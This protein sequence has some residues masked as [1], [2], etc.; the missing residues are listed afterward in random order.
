MKQRHASF[1]LF[2]AV[3]L[4]LTGCS[5]VS[6][7]R[8]RDKNDSAP[9][10]AVDINKIPNAVPKREPYS[11]YGN[12]NFTSYVVNGHRYHILKNAKN[13]DET[14]IASWY[15]MKFDKFR[16]SSGEPYSVTGMSAASKTLPLPTYVQVTNL[17][18][19][20]QVIVKVNDRGPFHEN[21]IIDLSYVAAAKIGMLPT[22]TALVRV[23]AIDP[24]QPEITTTTEST[25]TLPLMAGHPQ[26]YLQIGAFR[27]ESNAN[28]LEEK[29]KAKT[30]YPVK[31]RIAEKENAPIY[32][33]Q[34]GPIPDVDNTD[35]LHDSLEKA[36]LGEPI[37][38]IQ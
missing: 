28:T 23:K 19:N 34:I 7:H 5:T 15:G 17:K 6:Q 13:Y 32:R 25:P 31:V 3:I 26:I 38:V 21:R 27:V 30:H 33:V 11:K 10:F 8:Y 29:V 35:A 24:D 2:C 36:G 14:G 1:L 12:F 16:T 9:R 20:K 37:T 18:N 4:T 22:G